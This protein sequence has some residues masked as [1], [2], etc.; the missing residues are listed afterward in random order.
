LKEKKLH[1]ATIFVFVTP[2]AFHEYAM[3][4]MTLPRARAYAAAAVQELQGSRWKV[5]DAFAL[6]VG[7]PEF[8][9]YVALE[10]ANYTCGVS[11][12]ITNLAINSACFM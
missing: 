12:A 10:S 8:R 11:Y 2:P 9:G 4:R 3:P 7:R 5:V 6:S 1:P